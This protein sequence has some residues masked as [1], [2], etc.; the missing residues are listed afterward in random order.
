MSPPIRTYISQY[1]DKFN[2]IAFFCACESGENYNT[3]KD[4]ESLCNKKSVAT[5][6]FKREGVL[7]GNYF[8]KV[9]RFINGMLS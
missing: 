5:L 1:K 9:K 6:E 7:E 4:I 3:F 2:Q 8:P